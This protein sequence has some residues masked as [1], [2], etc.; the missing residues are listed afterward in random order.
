MRYLGIPASACFGPEGE[1]REFLKLVRNNRN[2][3]DWRT[4]VSAANRRIPQNTA[5]RGAPTWPNTRSGFFASTPAWLVGSLRQGFPADLAARRAV[6]RAK[7]RYSKMI[8]SFQSSTFVLFRSTERIATVR[9]RP[10]GWHPDCPGEGCC[11]CK[12][13]AIKFWT[14]SVRARTAE[15]CARSIR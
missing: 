10:Q 15:S 2:K 14:R 13:A 6:D 9:I 7:Q 11:L 1:V 4:V 3:K 12:L 8:N 5:T